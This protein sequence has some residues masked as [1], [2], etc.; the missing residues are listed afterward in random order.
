MSERQT[1]LP[2][3]WPHWAAPSNDLGLGIDR[4]MVAAVATTTPAE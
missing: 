4:S 1:A 3:M 2:A